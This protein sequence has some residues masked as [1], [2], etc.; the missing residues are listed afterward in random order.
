MFSFGKIEPSFYAEQEVVKA[1]LAEPTS[2][3]I[4]GQSDPNLTVRFG[5]SYGVKNMQ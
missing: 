1:A 2:P 3:P 5:S 4:M